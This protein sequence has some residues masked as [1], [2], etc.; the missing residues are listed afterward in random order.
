[1]RKTAFFSVLF[2]YLVLTVL[3]GCAGLDKT[4]NL[5]EYKADRDCFV[6]EGEM[7]WK[8]VEEAFGEPDQ[9]PLPSG[10]SLSKNARIYE[11]KILIFYTEQKRIKIQ[12]KIRYPEVVTKLEICTKK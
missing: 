3:S 12:G 8:D 9:L 11:N 1:M 4:V 5:E 2:V 6:Y 10:E 7:A